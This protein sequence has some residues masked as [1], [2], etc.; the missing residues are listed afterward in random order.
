MNMMNTIAEIIP[1]TKFVTDAKMWMKFVT[2]KC[3]DVTV[4]TL[5][6]FTMVNVSYGILFPKLF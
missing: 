5:P 6:F 1:T 2:D 3:K 4:T